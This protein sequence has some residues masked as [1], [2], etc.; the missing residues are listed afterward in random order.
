M[1]QQLFKMDGKMGVCKSCGG[2]AGVHKADCS[3]KPMKKKAKPMEAQESEMGEGM[4][5][6]GQEM[7]GKSKKPMKKSV[8]ARAGIR[9]YVRSLFIGS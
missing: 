9:D 6:E 4:D 2:K 5:N 1:Y 8:E 3:A 7:K